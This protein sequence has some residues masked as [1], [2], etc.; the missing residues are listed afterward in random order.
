MSDDLV[1]PPFYFDRYINGV[2]MAE[3]VCVERE[4][5]LES[6]M[7]VAARIASKG[8]NGEAP[9]LV[10]RAPVTHPAPDAAARQDAKEA[11]AYAEELEVKL[12]ECEA[13][14][15]KAV[16]RLTNLEKSASEVSRYGAATGP[17]WTKMSIDILAAR[18]TLAEIKSGVATTPYGLEGESHD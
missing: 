15:G 10:Y 2:R 16:E 12:A 17:Q 4:T 5:T 14:L 7:L 18:A 13:R 8:P 11:E 9:V 3:D 6:A 1:K